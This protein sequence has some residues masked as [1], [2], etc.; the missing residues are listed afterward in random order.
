MNYRVIKC[1]EAL[2]DGRTIYFSKG[3]VI[4]THDRIKIDD[5]KDC[6]DPIVRISSNSQNPIINER[7][8]DSV[9]L[10]IEKVPKPRGRGAKKH[11]NP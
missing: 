2:L 7:S 8:Q 11:G 5:H 6:L 3:D 1:F 4:S 10:T 9:N